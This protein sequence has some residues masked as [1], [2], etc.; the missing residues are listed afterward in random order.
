MER[1]LL[2]KLLPTMSKGSSTSP[3]APTLS[4]P[5]APQLVCSDIRI[6]VKTL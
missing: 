5:S 2:G 4:H 3:M 1:G 6:K